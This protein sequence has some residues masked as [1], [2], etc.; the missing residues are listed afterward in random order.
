MNQHLEFL[1]QERQRLV[2]EEEEREVLIDSAELY[3]ALVKCCPDAVVISDLNGRI[4]DA[5]DKALE[6]SGSSSYGDLIGKM[7]FD[8]IAEIDRQRAISNVKITLEK[9]ELINEVYC[10]LKQDG[11]E[12]M[13]ILSTSLVR[14]ESGE[15]KAFIAVL[16]SC[17][18]LPCG[19]NC[20]MIKENGNARR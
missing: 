5:S 19:E 9:G 11:T 16:R 12:Y 6:M 7:S 8:F 3:R 14:D 18:H 17:E 13:G 10:L 2:Q 20:K 4:I 1:E 15:P